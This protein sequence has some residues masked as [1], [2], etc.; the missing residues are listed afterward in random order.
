MLVFDVSGHLPAFT[1]EVEQRMDKLKQI[2]AT[3]G[4]AAHAELSELGSYAGIAI[5]SSIPIEDL[6]GPFGNPCCD[7]RETVEVR[8]LTALAR[9]NILID[10]WNWHYEDGAAHVV[11]NA[12]RDAIEADILAIEQAQLD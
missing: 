7:I 11:V 10:D 8:R 1:E 3:P 2:E 4:T 6:S 5:F 9:L 12:A